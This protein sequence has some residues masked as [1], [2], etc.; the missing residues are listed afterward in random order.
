MEEPEWQPPNAYHRFCLRHLLSNF[1]R[2]MGN[3]Q[4]KKLFGKTAEQRQ[5]VKVMNDLMAIATAKREAIFWI[6]DVGDMSKWSLCHDGGHRY[7]VTNTNLAEVFN[8]VMKD[9]RFLPL[10]TLVEFTFYRVNNYFV[11]RRE[12]ASAWL[13]GGHMYT[14]HATRIINRNTEK[15]NFHDIIA[16]DYKRG[17]FEVKIGRGTRGSSKGGKIQHVDLNKMKCTCNEFEI[18]HLPCSHVL[19]VCIKRHLS[20]E[21]FVDPSY[22]S[23]SYACT[24]EHYFMPMIDKR[25][26]LQYTGFELRDGSNSSRTPKP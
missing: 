11:Q 9:V 5:Q 8:Y 10:T 26:W 23:Q 16:F 18:Y 22:T 13:L 19:V 4:L 14:A 20:Y 6:D 2:A 17:V 15:A 24:Y 25:S 12:C 7:G 21:R 1:N 3:V